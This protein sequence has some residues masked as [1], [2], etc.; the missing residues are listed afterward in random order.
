MKINYSSK[1]FTLIE[2]LVVISIIAVLASIAV[3]AFTGVQ[4]RAA[5]T[6]ALNNAKQIG[7]SCKIFA[8]DNNGGYPTYT[9]DANLKPTTTQV[10]DSNTAFA[11]LIPDYLQTEDIFWLAKSKWCS[12]SPPDGRYDNPQLSS[13]AQT[14]VEGENEWALV[15]GLSDTSNSSYPLIANGFT[16]GGQTSHQYSIDQSEKGGVW[17]GKKAI[18]VRCDTSAAVMRVDPT[19][20]TVKGPVGASQDDDI[21]ST[22]HSAD[23]W[24]GS[25]NV[26]ANPK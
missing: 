25:T 16:D 6:K 17:K 1:A 3:P 19:S 20:L 2:L 22:T 11:Q 26:V 12:T 15:L 10:S 5:Q 24:L 4:E 23:G 8:Q 13:P 9:L 18:V 14:L 7:L 21:F